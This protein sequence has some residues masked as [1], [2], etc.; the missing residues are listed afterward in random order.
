M[1]CPGTC[2][3]GSGARATDEALRDR[4]SRTDE[5]LPAPEPKPGG[6][7]SRSYRARSE[8]P[9]V[10]RDHGTFGLRQDDPAQHYCRLRESRSGQVFCRRQAGERDRP[11]SRRRIPGVCAFPVDDR[12]AQYRFRHA[13]R[14]KM[15]A[16]RSRA[17]CPRS[18][19]G[20]VLPTFAMPF[21]RTCPEEMRQR[22]A[23]ARILAID[24]PVMLMDEPFGALDALTGAPCRKNS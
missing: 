7:R 19:S 4:G 20:W 8:R 15:V 10:S 21:P 16:R 11:R 13:R 23:I 5:S 22:V 9:R 3:A 18:S 24:S 14:E 6:G 17:G 1:P 12:R 2:C